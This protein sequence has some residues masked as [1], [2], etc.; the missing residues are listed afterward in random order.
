MN[1]YLNIL[2]PNRLPYKLRRIGPNRDGSY[3]LPD[4]L[5][6]IEACFSPGTNNRKDFEDV[7][8]I[9][10]K[11][12]S[13]MCDFSSDFDKFETALIKD[14]QFFEK[15]WLDINKSQDSI[16]LEKWVNSNVPNL[17]SDL[18]LQ[19]DIEGAEY[20][21]LLA[22]SDSLLKRFRILVI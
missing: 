6:G 1:S 2:K 8:A 11:I 18:L 22:I 12:K 5:E 19:M 17:D 4:D 16:T 20:R 9:K 21:N 14:M 3:I 7:L 10:Y 15:K 13:F